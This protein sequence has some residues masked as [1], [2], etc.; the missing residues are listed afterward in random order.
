MK[1]KAKRHSK[2][3]VISAETLLTAPLIAPAALA[4]DGMITT[5]EGMLGSFDRPVE[6]QV[7]RLIR[8]TTALRDG[9]SGGRAARRPK[10]R[11]KP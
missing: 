11:R 9:A 7:Q 4:L 8:L 5:L 2:S 1:K 10:R 6:A 3:A